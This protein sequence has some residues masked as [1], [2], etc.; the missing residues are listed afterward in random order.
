MIHT[1]NHQRPRLCR[2]NR[3]VSVDCVFSHSTSLHGFTAS[4]HQAKS[5]VGGHVGARQ[6]IR[7]SALANSLD[8]IDV[9][10]GGLMPG[11]RGVDRTRSTWEYDGP[12]NERTC[13]AHAI[14]LVSAL[15][16]AAHTRTPYPLFSPPLLLL[17]LFRSTFLSVS[18]GTMMKSKL[19]SGRS[20]LTNVACWIYVAVYQASDENVSP[21]E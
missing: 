19:R 5:S 10:I 14:A 6:T 18:R 3:W 11:D 4:F 8:D 21:Y 15:L 9:S 2:Y 17:T 20:I 12:H 1:L 7:V 16:H 13:N